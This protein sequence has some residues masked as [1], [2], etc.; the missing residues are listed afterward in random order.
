LLGHKGPQP[1][2]SSGV[3][4]GSGPT[5]EGTVGGDR[6][7]DSIGRGSARLSAPK[8]GGGLFRDRGGRVKPLYMPSRLGLVTIIVNYKAQGPA[9]RPVSG[10]NSSSLGLW[11]ERNLVKSELAGVPK[12]VDCGTPKT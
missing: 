3:T 4:L 1:A 2:Q 9:V 12:T 10:N 6:P 8:A 7:V 5:P 11:R